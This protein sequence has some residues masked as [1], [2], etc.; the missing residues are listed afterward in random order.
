MKKQLLLIIEKENEMLAYLVQIQ[1]KVVLLAKDIVT[2]EADLQKI[3][4]TWG[5]SFKGSKEIIICLQTECLTMGW[6]EVQTRD[7]EEGKLLLK[8]LVAESLFC[9]LNEITWLI[10]DSKKEEKAI[11]YLC[12]AGEKKQLALAGKKYEYRGL[13]GAN[14]AGWE[15]LSYNLIGREEDKALKVAEKIAKGEKIRYLSKLGKGINSFRLI[16]ISFMLILLLIA[17]LTIINQQIEHEIISL[18]SGVVEVIGLNENE[19]WRGIYEQ[20]IVRKTKWG[21]LATA[22]LTVELQGVKFLELEQIEMGQQIVC[23]FQSLKLLS[24]YQLMLEQNLNGSKL[25]LISVELLDE[26]N[27]RTVFFVEEVS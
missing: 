12:L 26:G 14:L 7:E 13:N 19:D 17:G 22:V 2:S 24:S 11:S 18:N 1:P 6:L 8:M 10:I 15:A 9:S 23:Q 16:T 25:Q 3:I 5:R 20:E 4:K 21:K 27:Y